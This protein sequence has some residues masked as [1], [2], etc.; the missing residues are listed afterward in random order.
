MT[1]TTAMRINEAAERL[2]RVPDLGKKV[3]HKRADTYVR[4][5]IALDPDTAAQRSTSRAQR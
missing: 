2:A 3:E 5:S 4:H 1:K